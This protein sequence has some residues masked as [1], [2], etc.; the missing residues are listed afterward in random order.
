[1]TT[2]RT[3]APTLT[4]GRLTFTLEVGDGQ[5]FSDE[6]GRVNLGF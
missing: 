2:G 6:T 3:G 1:M 5:M 4:I